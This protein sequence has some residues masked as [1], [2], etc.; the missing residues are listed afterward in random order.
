MLN[1][2]DYTAITILGSINLE[3]VERPHFKNR[4]METLKTGERKKEKKKN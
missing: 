2:V 1:T 3:C 4:K